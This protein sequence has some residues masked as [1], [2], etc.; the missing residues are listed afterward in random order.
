[1]YRYLGEGIRIQVELLGAGLQGRLLS[2]PLRG[3]NSFN[4]EEFFMLLMTLEQ[5]S[6]AAPLAASFGD[7]GSSSGYCYKSTGI[8]FPQ[9]I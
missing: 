4:L 8:K 2:L 9:K 7:S 3:Q 6:G 1:M 5:Y